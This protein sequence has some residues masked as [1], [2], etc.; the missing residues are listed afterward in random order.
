[1]WSLIST[2]VVCQQPCERCPTICLDCLRLITLMSRLGD[3]RLTV[4]SKYWQGFR[5]LGAYQGILADL[6]YRAKFQAD[7]PLLNQL[8]V[9]FADRLPDRQVLNDGVVIPVPMKIDRHLKRGFN[10]AELLARTIAGRRGLQFNPRLIKHT[11]VARVQHLLTRAERLKN[12]RAAFQCLG[13][14]PAVAYVVDDVYT[15]GATAQAMC[16]LLKA[17]GCQ[18][19]E[20]WIIAK[21]V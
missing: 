2:C 4:F 10:Q 17:N 16:S 7:L 11:G 12:M 14:A 15:T 9:L 18:Y 19:I 8:A 20:L 5:C 1:M 21:T 3:P 6:V 13:P